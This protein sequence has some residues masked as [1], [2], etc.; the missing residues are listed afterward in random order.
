MSRK[1]R[2][3][4]NIKVSVASSKLDNEI[5]SLKNVC[6]V[7]LIHVVVGKQNN[8]QRQLSFKKQKI[9]ITLATV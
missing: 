2:D 8:S 7:Q 6:G 9:K 3:G 4:V 5:R 1:L